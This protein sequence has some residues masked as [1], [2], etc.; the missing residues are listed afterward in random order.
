MAPFVYDGVPGYG[1]LFAG[2]K[3]CVLQRVPIRSTL[4][5]NVEVRS[6]IVVAKKLLTVTEQWRRNCPLGKA[7]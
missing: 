5:R 4:I 1:D 7:R 3:F 2:I 6:S